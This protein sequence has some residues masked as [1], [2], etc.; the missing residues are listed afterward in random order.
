MYPL[1]VLPP[2]PKVGAK[3]TIRDLNSIF[4]FLKFYQLKFCLLPDFLRP[5][6]KSPYVFQTSNGHNIEVSGRG[7]EESRVE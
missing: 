7:I 5:V 4:N 1:P 2:F 6:L 3:L